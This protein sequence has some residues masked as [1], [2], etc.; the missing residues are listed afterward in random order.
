MIKCGVYC[1]WNT[2]KRMAYIGSSKDIEKRIKTHFRKLKKGN[3]HCRYLQNA[4]NK[5]Q[6]H[7]FVWS[8]TELCLE[9][10]LLVREQYYMDRF[11]NSKYN[12]ALF[13]HSPMKGRKHSQKTLERLREV[14]K[15]NQHNLGNKASESTRLKMSETRKKWLWS[16]E[17]K[18]KMSDTAKRTKSISRVDFNKIRRKIQDS[19][20]VV[21]SSLTDAARQLGI[22]TQAVCDNLKGRSKVTQIGLTFTYAVV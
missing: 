11:K 12:A 1:I 22:S 16:E 21:Y 20:G 4:Y 19:N 15:G 5:Y 9:S 7:S 14:H 10:D 18:K 13:S 17:V 8:V 6:K 2:K 3:H